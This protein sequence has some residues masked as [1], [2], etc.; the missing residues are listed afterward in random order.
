MFHCL[1]LIYREEHLLTTRYAYVR[2]Q[3]VIV[4]RAYQLHFDFCNCWF[5]FI[6]KLALQCQQ[7]LFL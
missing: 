6:F 1:F 3:A 2:M 7:L 4:C 5:V